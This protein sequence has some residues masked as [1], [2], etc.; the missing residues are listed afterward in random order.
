[1]WVPCLPSHAPARWQAGIPAGATKNRVT[2]LPL[3]RLALW[4]AGSESE[5]RSFLTLFFFLIAV[6]LSFS[7]LRSDFMMQVPCLQGHLC[8]IKKEY[9]HFH[10]TMLRVA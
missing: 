8:L 4:Q 3:H 7:A 5:E 10:T 9:Y 1:M 6:S 2:C